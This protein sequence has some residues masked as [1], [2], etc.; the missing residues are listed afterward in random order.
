MVAGRVG[1]LFAPSVYIILAW[2]FALLYVHSLAFVSTST[3]LAINLTSLCNTHTTCE[4]CRSE[5]NETRT[6]GWCYLLEDPRIGHCIDGTKKEPS[7]TCHS[8]IHRD[9]PKLNTTA[10]EVQWSFRR[11]PKVDECKLVLDN[12]HANATCKDTATSF[13]CVCRPG[14]R[15]DGVKVCQRTCDIECRQGTCSEDPEFK[16]NCDLGWTGSDCG[17]RCGCNNSTCLKQVRV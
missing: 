15:G 6:C 13:T 11:C 12:C 1:W 10:V 4:S 7:S 17:I 8:L 5:S 14:F 2:I 16:C 9:F 3:D